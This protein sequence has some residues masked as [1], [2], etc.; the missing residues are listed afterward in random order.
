MTLRFKINEPTNG[1]N[2]C[3]G[4]TTIS[5]L[6]IA[7]LLK[8]NGT[9]IIQE[10]DV[11]S[12][13]GLVSAIITSNG[14]VVSFADIV[15]DVVTVIIE[16]DTPSSTADVYI[17]ID[18]D[19]YR[20]FENT[21][22]VYGYDLGNN[23]DVNNNQGLPVN[24][25]P[26]MNITIIPNS[27]TDPYSS[28]VVYQK[29][30]TNTYHVYKLDSSLGIVKY[31][32]NDN[33]L[34]L[35]TKNGLICNKDEVRIKQITSIDDEVCITAL[36]VVNKKFVLPVF[37]INNECSSCLDGCISTENTA[38][39]ILEIFNNGIFNYQNDQLISGYEYFNIYWYLYS[40][41][42]ELL[43]SQ[44]YTVEGLLNIDTF[45]PYAYAFDY[46]PPEKGDYVVQVKLEFEQEFTCTKTLSLA[47]CN[48][49]DY[50]KKDCNIVEFKN[51]S[52][53]DIQVEIYSF[54]LNS[55]EFNTLVE[56]FTI[57]KASVYEFKFS[58]DG[59]Y[60]VIGA[61]GDAEYTYVLPVYCSIE[62][63]YNEFIKT[64]LCIN[65][66]DKVSESWMY[67]F[68]VFFS[69]YLTYFSLLNK[70][71]YFVNFIGNFDNKVIED[72][73]TLQKIHD[74]LYKYCDVCLNPKDTDCGC[75]C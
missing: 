50:T 42:G 39:A 61:R 2:P 9:T 23:P 31:Y 51:S 46:T 75:G 18:K 8:V 26:N 25:N 24:S 13:T 12:F 5:Y 54:D 14:T 32:N 63:C 1:S 16:L 7:L 45:N 64:H 53:E 65:C 34:L 48:W 30:Y 17:K 38:K 40:I 56:T 43:Q 28:F 15:D 35:E 47:A 60:K 29:P 70:Y 27:V 3:N 11:S 33:N 62:R 10:S 55:K 19:N 36:Q 66:K 22:R 44:F 59:L 74:S 69:M 73:F 52:L 4:V 21:F 49:F 57:S 71:N 37:Y 67:K 41:D 6:D 20:S 72:L 58:K 68:N